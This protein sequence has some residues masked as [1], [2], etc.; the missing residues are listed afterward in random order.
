MFFF[1][2]DIQWK[3]LLESLHVLNIPDP[4]V[5]VHLSVVIYR[6]THTYINIYFYE[7]YDNRLY[8]LYQY[9]IVWYKIYSIYDN[10]VKK[11][12]LG[13]GYNPALKD[14]TLSSEKMLILQSL[15]CI[16]LIKF[17]CLFLAFVF[18]SAWS[19]RITQYTWKCK[20]VF[21]CVTF[22]PGIKI[23][24]FQSILSQ[25]VIRDALEGSMKLK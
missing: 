13:R 5:P 11:K 18:H 19:K 12:I 14:M 6:N 15:S 8:Y 21:C 10:S 2:Q 16:K 1:L 25:L 24:H 7:Q 17:L 20:S 23:S 22:S 4:G 9:L 3:E